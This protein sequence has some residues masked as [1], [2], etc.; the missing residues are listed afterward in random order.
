MLFGEEMRVSGDETYK[1][2]T[3]GRDIIGVAH[4]CEQECP[5]CNPQVLNAGFDA[6]LVAARDALL[7][8]EYPL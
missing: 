3:R 2:A 4:G 8:R 7:D 5:V 1:S 6:Q